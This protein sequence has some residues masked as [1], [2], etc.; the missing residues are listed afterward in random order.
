MGKKA[1]IW[2]YALFLLSAAVLLNGCALL[3]MAMGVVQMGAGLVGQAMQLA[4]SMPT[5]PPWMFF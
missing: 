1:G 4:Q 5:P 2:V 3:Q